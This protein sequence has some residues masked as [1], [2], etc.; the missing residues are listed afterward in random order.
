MSRNDDFRVVDVARPLR[1]VN[2]DGG[3]WAVEMPQAASSA[4]SRRPRR[5]GALEVECAFA[6]GARIPS[7]SHSI[8]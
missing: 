7:A 8:T 4:S 2:K 1:A 6:S 5:G 3:P